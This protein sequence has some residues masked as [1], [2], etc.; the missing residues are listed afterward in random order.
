M[1]AP[2]GGG[3]AQNAPHSGTLEHEVTGMTAPDRFG[4]G[5]LGGVISQ[6]G[7]PS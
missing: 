2:T 6:K 4:T 3:T 5:S 1:R 7:L